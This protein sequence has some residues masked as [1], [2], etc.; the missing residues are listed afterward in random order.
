M[1]SNQC[2]KFNLLVPLLVRHTSQLGLKVEDPLL[3]R[4]LQQSVMSDALERI[5]HACAAFC[6]GS[7]IAG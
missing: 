7:V 6:K 4:F 3:V 2:Q 1:L 5:M